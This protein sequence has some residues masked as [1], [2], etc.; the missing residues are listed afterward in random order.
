[1]K[2]TQDQIQELYLFTQNH[3]VEHYDLQTELVDHLANGIEVQMMRQPKLTFKEALSLEFK[4]FG[5]FGFHDVIKEKTNAMEKRYWKIFLRFYK[6][7]FKLPK[8]SLLIGVSL[9]LFFAMR[10]VPKEVGKYVPGLSIMVILVIFYVIL[11]RNRRNQKA[12]VRKWL[13]G[14]MIAANGNVFLGL[15]FVLQFAMFPGFVEEILEKPVG[16]FLIS[17]GI[18]LLFLLFHVMV[19]VIPPKAEELLSE[20]YPEYKMVE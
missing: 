11:F 8:V 18:V 10:T 13:L 4:K 6:E 15:N 7:Y 19:N 16:A 1:M 20:T 2:L 3:F 5:A 12:K 17:F 14:D 9:L